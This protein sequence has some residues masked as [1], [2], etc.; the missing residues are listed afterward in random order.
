[1]WTTFSLLKPK[2]EF[3]VF[4]RNNLKYFFVFE[5]N[6]EKTKGGAPLKESMW[7]ATVC[8]DTDL[9]FSWFKIQTRQNI[10]YWKL[11]T[12]NV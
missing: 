8:I 6:I 10:F 7:E 5:W 3:N 2:E 11:H 4:F 12:K 1:M 9:P